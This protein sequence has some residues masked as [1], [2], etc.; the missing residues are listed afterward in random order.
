[1]HLLQGHVLT[2]AQV[3]FFYPNSKIAEIL[4]YAIIC[5]HGKKVGFTN[6]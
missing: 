4:N 1:M 5:Q 3:L 2:A 6:D